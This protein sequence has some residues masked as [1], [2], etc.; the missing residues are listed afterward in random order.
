MLSKSIL[1][2]IAKCVPV[3]LA[4][5]IVAMYL[6]SAYAA[7]TDTGR[8]IENRN[9]GPDGRFGTADDTLIG[10]MST[11]GVTKAQARDILG[12][13]LDDLDALNGPMVATDA[14]GN[15]IPGKNG[16]PQLVL[17]NNT[18]VEGNLSAPVDASLAIR[19]GHAFLA[20]IAVNAIP[21]VDANGTL[22]PDPDSV[23]GLSQPGTYDN[24]LFDAHYIAGDPRANENIGLTTV[25]S[26]FHSEH[27]RLVNHTKEV[28]LRTGD[29]AFLSQWLMPG[30]APATFPATPQDIANLTWNGE[31]LFQVARFGTE[32]QYQHLQFEEFAH[33]IAPDVHGF[34][35]YDAAID[36]A[37]TTE[38][39]QAAY[40]MGH[41]MLRETI[42]RTDANGTANDI[43]LLQAFLNPPEFAASGP[44]PKQAAGAIVRGLTRETGN[45]IDEFVTETLRNKLLGL[46]LDL[47][48]INLARGRDIGIPPLNEVRRQFFNATGDSF[49]K[50]YDSWEE[51]SLHM[52]HNE[53]LINFI[54]AYGTHPSVVS[55]TTLAE[56]RAAAS[57]IVLGGAGAP[58]DRIDFL[59]ST[60]TWASAPGT[61]KTGLDDVDL[62][63]GGLAE[64][65]MPFGGMLGSTLNFVFR[66][67]EE[68]LQDG[69]RFYYL[70]RLAGL[71]FRN[72]IEENL[73][74]DMVMRNTDTKHLPASIFLTPTYVFEVGNLIVD[75]NNPARFLDDPTTPWNESQLLIRMP[76]GT[77]TYAPP[78]SL[79]PLLFPATAATSITMGGTPGNDR[80]Q[81]GAADD[82]TL[83]GDGGNDRLDG[84]AG[85]DF[86]SGGN[87]DDILTDS[88]GDDVIRGDNGND[89][90]SDRTG[91]NFLIGGN[92]NDF[93]ITA[94]DKFGRSFGG[95][96]NDFILGGTGGLEVHQGGSGDD[97]IE[98][99]GG[100]DE[101]FGDMADELRLNPI[102]GNDVLSGKGNPVVLTGGFGDDIMKMGLG[103]QKAR[104]FQG[105]DWAIHQGDP[106]PANS[107]LSFPE[108]PE[109][110]G[111][112]E[113]RDRF[114]F[115]EG[116]SGW[117]LNDTLLGDNRT[118]ARMLGDE[119]NNTALIDGLQDLLGPGVTQF[120]GGNIILGGDGSDIIQGQ[121]GDDLIDGDAW[122]NVRLSVRDKATGI[123]IKSA[124]SLTEL[125]AAVLA[126]TIN[127]G[128]IK[129]MREILTPATT[130]DDIDTAVFSGNFKD[131]KISKPDARGVITVTDKRANRRAGGG[132]GGGGITD[133]TD[134]LRNIERLQF[135]DRTVD[136]GRSNA[137]KPPV[138]KHIPQPEEPPITYVG[139]QFTRLDLEFILKQIKIAEAN[140]TGT[141]LESMVQIPTL[142]FGLRTV[143]GSFNNIVPGQAAFGTADRVHPRLTTPVFRTAENGT[144][145]AQTSGT[146]FD[147]RPRVIS[148]LIVD[149]TST[150][151]AAVA[152]AGNI[153]GAPGQTLFIENVAPDFGLTV[154]FNMWMVFFGQFF[155][156]GLDFVNKGGNGAVII[157]LQPDDPLFN[158]SS[159]TNFMVLNRATDLPGPDGVLGTADDIH[160]HTN[161]VSPF[162]DQSQTYTSH[163]SH[164]VFLR[165]YM[166]SSLRP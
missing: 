13:E 92:G 153:T 136:L 140:A 87:G 112:G 71:D 20:D 106:L 119:L 152:A 117:N 115:V 127:P 50:P 6:P 18:L 73:F 102:I 95:T 75:P 156:H 84:G 64:E 22:L 94:N 51:Y 4:L 90:I 38:F 118:A 123:E 146:V 157:P 135:A 36:P 149:Q 11:W 109:I 131:Y 147:S 128:E 55:A 2:S 161:G 104:G 14:Y 76:D 74:T 162:V 35:G 114:I 88:F 150:N 86:I 99:R 101:L 59:R 67:Q 151:P 158:A 110:I 165:E 111:Q 58:A 122:L 16:F 125:Q 124:N 24:E 160:E 154:P 129:I 46:P 91:L 163:P 57:L 34:T 70:K 54:A 166:N 79:N 48:A 28:I 142:Q 7:S 33:R 52:R 9:L 120:T 164:Q 80:M 143:D 1:N 65:K 89:T 25:H 130:A 82:D 98:D 105:F 155:D 19:T 96:G 8:L 132:G 141:P 23:I 103:T 137:V 44:T 159:P 66:K 12:I 93:I 126:G 116:L 47:P 77:V 3:L 108:V 26:I 42:N 31:R 78:A 60:G 32:M 21:I 29:L 56:K 138:L 53:S 27:N 100:E 45:E 72:Q 10:G 145:Y 121:G 83:W 40:R 85:N 61:T 133:G 62:W 107:D 41:S 113:L 39:A 37:I 139:T 81:S 68:D 97:W 15:F 144:S 148:N 5:S 49:L 17:P 134:T 30:T 69:D 63:V 43:T